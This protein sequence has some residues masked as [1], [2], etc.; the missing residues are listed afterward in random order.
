MFTNLKKTNSKTQDLYW[1][2]FSE[3]LMEWKCQQF[4][5]K[6]LTSLKGFE[7]NK[8]VD[9]PSLSNW[10]EFIKAAIE[11]SEW[12]GYPGLCI[13]VINGYIKVIKILYPI[14]NKIHI[15]IYKIIIIGEVKNK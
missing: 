2:I 14:Y 12:K 7:I 3:I 1:T 15:G 8:F 11:E 6:W 10:L 13:T 5:V 4:L 9:N